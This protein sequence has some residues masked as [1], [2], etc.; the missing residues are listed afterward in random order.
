L[1]SEEFD[2][3]TIPTIGFNFKELKKGKINLKMWDLGGQSKFREA[4]EKYCR[5]SDCIIFVVD[6]ADISNLDES[7]KE[8][9]ALMQCPSL[10]GIPLLL[11]GNKNDLEGALT[12]EELI[13][14]MSLRQI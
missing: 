2:E 8:L 4:W 13:E 9:H 1:A 11:L 3:D 7:R 10:V 12:E 6:S 5:H 14:E